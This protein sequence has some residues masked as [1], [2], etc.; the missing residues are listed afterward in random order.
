MGNNIPFGFILV[1]P[2][3]GLLVRPYSK[4]VGADKISLIRFQRRLG[5]EWYSEREISI[6]EAANLTKK[7]KK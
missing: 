1:F 3:T 5:I 7:A 6:K 4:L 2:E